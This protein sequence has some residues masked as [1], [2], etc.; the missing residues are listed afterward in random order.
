MF[1]GKL[2]CEGSCPS[3]PSI[4]DFQIST[5]VGRAAHFDQ[6]AIY[7]NVL[8]TWMAAKRLVG[9]IKSILKQMIFILIANYLLQIHV[10]VHVHTYFNSYYILPSFSVF[11]PQVSKCA[12]ILEQIHLDVGHK[13][14]RDR[15]TVIKEFS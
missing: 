10:S 15:S 1:F 2:Y 5:A 8:E 7:K 14:K 9:L 13:D 4:L 3:G 11:T 6:I 12:L